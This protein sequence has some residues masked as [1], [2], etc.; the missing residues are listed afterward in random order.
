MAVKITDGSVW[1]IHMN[2]VNAVSNDSKGNLGIK[3]FPKI[4]QQHGHDNNE[5]LSDN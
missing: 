3:E 5:E 4:K 1:L 2:D